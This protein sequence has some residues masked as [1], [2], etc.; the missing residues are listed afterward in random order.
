VSNGTDHRFRNR[1]FRAA[2]FSLVVAAAAYLYGLYLCTSAQDFAI[3]TAAYG[4]LNGAV[5]KLY[6]DAN[7]RDKED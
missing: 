4:V 1:K 6:N 7:L 3:A 2:A 5:L